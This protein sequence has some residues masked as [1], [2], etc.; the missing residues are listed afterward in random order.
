MELWIGCVAGA[1]RDSEYVE[2]LAA[3]GFD[4]VDIEA[5]RVYGIDEAREFLSGLGLDGLDA[6][7]VA[8]DVDGRFISAFIRATKPAPACC[9]PGC[10]A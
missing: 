1:L 6:E 10:C 5:T 9:S 3:A 7:S 4:N 8:K 2:K